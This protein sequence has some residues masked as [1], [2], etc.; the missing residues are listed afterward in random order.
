MPGRQSQ[1]RAMTTSYEPCTY[2][3]VDYLCTILVGVLDGV[4]GSCHFALGWRHK[5]AAQ[6]TLEEVDSGVG[7]G[8]GGDRKS[9]WVHIPA[10]DGGQTKVSNL[11]E[12]LLQCN[13]ESSQDS[14]K[15][16]EI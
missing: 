7:Q 14:A 4:L 3:S 13:L 16:F 12:E 15:D 11:L 5:R 8:L 6:Q 10:A 2:T 9:I 1:A